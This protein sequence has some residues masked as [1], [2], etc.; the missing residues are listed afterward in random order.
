M[1][2]YW[3]HLTILLLSISVTPG[4]IS[5]HAPLVPDKNFPNSWGTISALGPECKSL[6]GIYL[7]EGVTL[8]DGG[9][10]QH[11]MLTS[12]LNIH[13]N[14][15]TIE[16]TV[17]TREVDQNGDS[18]ITLQVVPSDNI[19]DVH[20]LKGC[21]CIKQTLVCTQVTENY[22]SIPNFWL[23]GSQKNIYFSMLHD[24]SLAAKL[25]NY[26]ADIVLGLPIFGMKEPWARF[27]R[28]DMSK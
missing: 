7:N 3:S 19:A 12:A 15:R 21:F 5:V 23:G 22:W 16:L 26:H 24:R 17:H 2:Q 25:Q 11:L 18:F 27:Y 14:A 1:N 6:D 28:V 9:E 13:S 4:C 20:E 10:Y 8:T